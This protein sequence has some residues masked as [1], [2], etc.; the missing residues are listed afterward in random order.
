MRR[1]VRT[2][3][4]NEV[5]SRTAGPLF[6]RVVSPP[7]P[8]PLAE[9]LVLFLFPRPTSKPEFYYPY[10]LPIYRKLP[11]YES[12]PGIGKNTNFFRYYS[13]Y[14][15]PHPWTTLGRS[16]R[17]KKGPLRPQVSPTNGSS[18]FSEAATRQTEPG[19]FCTVRHA[20]RAVARRRP[21]LGPRA[22]RPIIS[23]VV[24][25]RG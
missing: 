6:K 5:S 3:P 22:R 2:F 18:V 7:V 10:D 17:P 4:C 12:L 24:G 11:Q 20:V 23:R 15:F 14:R 19:R 16:G 1:N 21:G 8:W 25:R 9:V 13:P